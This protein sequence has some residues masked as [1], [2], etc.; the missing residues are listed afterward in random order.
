MPS[1]HVGWAVWVAWALHGHVRSV[2]GRVALLSYPVLTT[3]VVV[4]TGNHWLLDCVVGC[5]VVVVGIAAA[6]LTAG[7]K[8]LHGTAAKT[9]QLRHR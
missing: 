5:V 9:L 6:R 4:C 7:G 1:L 2:A 3:A 8:L